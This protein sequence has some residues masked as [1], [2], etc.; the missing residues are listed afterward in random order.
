M[1]KAVKDLTNH[2][3]KLSKL[4]SQQ[5]MPQFTLHFYKKQFFKN[6]GLDLKT[7]VKNKLR[8][9]TGLLSHR[10]QEQSF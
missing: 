5:K 6:K 10:T 7:K 8:A 9:K 1:T 3:L 2:L 4:F